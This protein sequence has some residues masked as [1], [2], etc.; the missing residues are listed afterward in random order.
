[1]DVVLHNKDNGHQNM[2]NY[3]SNNFRYVMQFSK[4]KKIKW[5]QARKQTKKINKYKKNNYT[6]I[7]KYGPKHVRLLLK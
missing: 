1:M 2:N 6:N 5:K 3:N 7:Q 4:T